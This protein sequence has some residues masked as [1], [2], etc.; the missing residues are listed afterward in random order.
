METAKRIRDRFSDQYTI[1]APDEKR[2]PAARHVA[3]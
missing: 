1:P 3:R 2:F